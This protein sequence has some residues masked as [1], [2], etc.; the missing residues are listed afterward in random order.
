MSTMRRIAVVGSSGSGKT[1]MARTLSERFGLTH[2]EL[3]ALHHGPN[4][5]QAEPDVLRRRV[6]DAM[7]AAPDGWAMCG[8]YESIVGDLRSAAA[9]TVVWLDLARPVVTRRVVTRTIRRAITREELWNGNR[10]PLSN[11]YRWDPEKNVIRWSWVHFHQKR[12]RYEAGIAGGVWDH[13]DLH[14][15]RTPSEVDDFLRMVAR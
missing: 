15:L 14:R 12:A 6:V 3:D 13:L 5:T 7:E 2:I 4:W 8:S 11:F 9:D 10:E 1:T